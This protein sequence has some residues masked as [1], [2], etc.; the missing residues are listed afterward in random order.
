MEIIKY[1]TNAD[2]EITHAEISHTETMGEATGTATD[3]FELRKPLEE[4]SEEAI[5][6]SIAIRS[7][8]ISNLISSAKR[9]AA[10]AS[11]T[12]TIV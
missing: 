3:L 11:L 8:Q 7:A 6:K 12:E 2:D 5:I 9:Q 4:Y 1:Y 10:I